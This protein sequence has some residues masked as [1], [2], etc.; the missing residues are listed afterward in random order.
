MCGSRGSLSWLAPTSNIP[1]LFC[2][3]LLTVVLSAQTAGAA[4]EFRTIDGSGNN[5]ANPLWGS[6][7]Q[8]LA[9]SG[10]AAY[11]D[12]ASTP[13][14]ASRPGAREISNAVSSQ[15]ATIPNA[16]GASGFLWQWGQFL[17]HDID[18]TGPA[19]PT[20][21]FDIPIL[22]GDAFFDPLGSGTASLPFHRSLHTTVGT[23]TQREQVN[24]IT[25][26]ID[27]S[28]V[29]GSDAQ[30]AA[31][32]RRFDGSGRLKTSRRRMP[33]RNTDGLPNAPSDLDPTM[34]LAGDVR[35]N[36][37][38]A[39]TV[40]HALFVREHN[41]LA[42][43]SKLLKSLREALGGDANDTP[44]TGEERYQLARILVGAEMQAITYNEFLP[45]L[46]GPTGLPAY[47]G[48]D[49]G[50][51]ATIANGFSTAA[52][53]FGHSMVTPTLS[54]LNRQLTDK[55][56]GPLPLKEAFF[57]PQKL[58]K[59][60]LAP[61]LRGLAVDRSQAIDT[62]VVDGLRNFLFGLPGQGGLDLAALNIQRGRD[63]GLADYN[64]FRT[65][66]GLTAVSDFDEITSDPDLQNTLF[67]LYGNVDDIDA[68]VG[69]LAEDR[70]A[71]S[72]LGELAFA[73]IK[74]QFERL[75]NGDR[76]WYQ[77]HLPPG[78]VAWV[79][80]R[81]LSKIIRRNTKVRS[82]LSANV[83]VAAP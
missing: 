38:V 41:R 63:H 71:D 9:R 64:A 47:A 30:R 15:V 18:L 40:M 48:Y 76:F 39:L 68:W 80:S 78:M 1:R 67:A 37:Q 55:P 20:E 27:A 61:Y 74:D 14:G 32:L 4:I 79:E 45:V 70:Y 72:L 65:A 26:F 10:P 29:Y 35:A 46:L 66:L 21:S 13:A 19:L 58:R 33:P 31:A 75:R 43:R 11:G 83:F 62:L 50:I 28:N 81:T 3:G 23:S 16:A 7:G 42:G 51:D 49:A 25:S 54:R 17:D 6:A 24:E 34:F 36:E 60:R 69:C 22:P 82:E 59:G 57:S 8:P 53:R 5:L 12:G 77:H 44:L 73:A 56:V 2:A 52:Y